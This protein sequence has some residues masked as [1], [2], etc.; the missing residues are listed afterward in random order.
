MANLAAEISGDHTAA[1]T[2]AGAA[3]TTAGKAE[4]KAKQAVDMGN[5]GANTTTGG[6]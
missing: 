2:A 3:K 4:A 6:E 1:Q 5:F